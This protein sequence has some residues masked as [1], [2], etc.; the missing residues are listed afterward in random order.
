MA[1][2][3]FSKQTK[4]EDFYL[5]AYLPITKTSYSKQTFKHNFYSIWL[6]EKQKRYLRFLSEASYLQGLQVYNFVE[7]HIQFRLP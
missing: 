2:F 7:L 4:I 3:N 6:K 1:F 5:M